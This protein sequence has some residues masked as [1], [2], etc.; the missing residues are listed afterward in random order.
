[1]ATLVFDYDGTLHEC[2]KIYAPAF[3]K[4]Y[5][6]LVSC[7]LMPER[8]WKDDEISIWL[9]YSSKD[10]WNSFAPKLSQEQKMYCSQLIGDEM[11]RLIESGQAKLYQGVLEILEKLKDDGHKLVFLS[12][13]KHNY[14]MAHRKFF[15]LDK[16]F[17][18]FYCTED[19]GWEPKEKIFETI[20]EDF[21]KE[22]I[23]I[24][25][26]FQDIAVAQKHNLKSIGCGYG[27]GKMEEL[28]SASVIV[29]SPEEIYF[30]C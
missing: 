16:Y 12:N 4:A 21:P 7:G 18:G 6:H 1:M 20:K 25:D 10:M 9:G 5:A 11:E 22:F 17:S 13:C 14:M 26:R 3:R 27:Y 15:Q 29:N 23:I 8:I 24:G 30:H 19:F 28:D 2:I